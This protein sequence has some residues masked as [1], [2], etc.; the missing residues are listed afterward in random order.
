MMYDGK[1]S[2]NEKFLLEKSDP[3][4]ESCVLAVPKHHNIPMNKYFQSIVPANF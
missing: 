4:N 1:R 2:V 3:A